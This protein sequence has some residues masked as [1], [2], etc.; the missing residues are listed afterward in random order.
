MTAHAP[1]PTID[2][3]RALQITAMLALIESMIT[4]GEAAQLLAVIKKSELGIISTFAGKT[5][6]LTLYGIR[7]VAL[8][9]TP[10]ALLT[11]WGTTAATR[12][13]DTL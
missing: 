5:P 11:A 4:R 7:A 13:A 2:P 8:S 3:A 6:T 10:E 1:L 12:L 9:T